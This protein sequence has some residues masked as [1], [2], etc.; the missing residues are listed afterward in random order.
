MMVDM[1]IFRVIIEKKLLR[2]SFDS[3]I[4]LLTLTPRCLRYVLQGV[5]H[6]NLII[7]ETWQKLNLTFIKVT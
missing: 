3:E 1:V 7:E 2:R 5:Y 6:V 4:V